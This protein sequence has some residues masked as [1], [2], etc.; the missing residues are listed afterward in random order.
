MQC[1]AQHQAVRHHAESTDGAARHARCRCSGPMRPCVTAHRRRQ[2]NA[3]QVR[4]CTGPAMQQ[5]TSTQRAH[6]THSPTRLPVPVGRH[7]GHCLLVTAPS[8]QHSTA[9][10]TAPHR[11][12]RYSTAHQS[13]PQHGNP[14]HGTALHSKAQHSKAK[15]GT[16]AQHSTA[17]HSTAHSTAQHS[18]AHSTQHRTAQHSTQHRTAQHG[19][20]QHST[21]QQ[22]KA[23]HSTQHSIARQSTAP[24]RHSTA[25]V[26]VTLVWCTAPGQTYFG[27]VRVG[28]MSHSSQQLQLPLCVPPMLHTK[29]FQR[30]C[31]LEGASPQCG[32]CNTGL[33]IPDPK[34]PVVRSISRHLALEEKQG[35]PGTGGGKVAGVVMGDARMSRTSAQAKK[36][37][38]TKC[39]PNPVWAI[40]FKTPPTARQPFPTR[41]ILPRNGFSNYSI[42][43]RAPAPSGAGKGG[44]KHCRP[45]TAKQT[46]PPTTH[47]LHI[48]SGRE[49][50][51]NVTHALG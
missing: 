16:G 12:A 20:A 11:T 13:T 7:P 1:S 25:C 5:H 2:S 9:Q 3:G 10:H 15:H 27:E 28:Q 8:A 21:A 17:P 32:K 41:Q 24:A 30:R 6:N 40:S 34:E 4:V 38:R 19:E 50:P 18:T 36:S 44:G 31:G 45:P 29:S 22:S 26:L 33:G 48:M 47:N 23:R 43:P 39:L 14:E 42:P 35:W 37:A 49:H 46:Q 51:P